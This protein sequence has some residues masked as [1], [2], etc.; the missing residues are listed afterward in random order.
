MQPPRIQLLG[1]HVSPSTSMNSVPWRAVKPRVSFSLAIAAF[2]GLLLGIALAFVLESPG[3]ALAMVPRKIAAFV[4][5]LQFPLGRGRALPPDAGDR[6][7]RLVDFRPFPAPL[8]RVRR[9]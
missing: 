3:T 1:S 6:G 9:K 7:W 4:L 8:T 2:F 5:P